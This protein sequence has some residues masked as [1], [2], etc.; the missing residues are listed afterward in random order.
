[1]RSTS[2]GEMETILESFISCMIQRGEEPRFNWD[3]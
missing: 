2:W 3:F 1:M